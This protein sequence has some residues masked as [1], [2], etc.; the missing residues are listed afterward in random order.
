MSRV[1]DTAALLEIVRNTQHLIV[2]LN[3]GA[4]SDGFVSCHRAPPPGGYKARFDKSI[5]GEFC[6]G[7]CSFSSLVRLCMCVQLLIG[8]L[9]LTGEE[10]HPAVTLMGT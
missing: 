3:N 1:I 7:T 2:A 8:D 6:K 4:N 9:V 10:A 5:C